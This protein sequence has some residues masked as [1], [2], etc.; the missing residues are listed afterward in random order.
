MNNYFARRAAAGQRLEKLGFE[1]SGAIPFRYQ[2]SHHSLT[3]DGLV[4]DAKA[5]TRYHIDV[6]GWS[7]VGYHALYERVGDKMVWIPGRPLSVMGAHVRG[8]NQESLG[9][10]Y[11]GNYDKDLPDWKGYL[12]VVRD[13]AI[14]FRIPIGDHLGHFET[15]QL[16]GKVQE[17]SCPGRLWSMPRFRAE[18][19]ALI[20]AE[21]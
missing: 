9:L 19:D 2:V 3:K 21:A 13:F 15:Y 14:W 12:P 17:K 1:L 7:D 6:K 5:I 4:V 10:C 11:V 18:L 8:F 20:E 16:M